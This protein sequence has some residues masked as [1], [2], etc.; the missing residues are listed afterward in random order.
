MTF[1][2]HISLYVLTGLII[3]LLDGVFIYFI[4]D[5][6]NRQIKLVQGSDIQVDIL[7]TILTY[8]VII[9][10]LYYFI[11]REKR[12]VIDAAFLGFSMYALYELTTK[13][14]LKQWKW[15]TVVIDITWG[16][17]LYA[18]STFIILRLTKVSK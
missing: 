7:A 10:S 6:F 12:S 17:I 16:S 8:I 18:L 3:L 13:S 1:G 15:T 4:K 11:I 9:F 2:N 5:M 14:L